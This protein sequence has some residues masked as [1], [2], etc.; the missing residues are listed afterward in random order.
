ML[1]M[2]PIWGEGSLLTPRSPTGRRSRVWGGPVQLCLS[3]VGATLR[4]EGWL[5]PSGKSV[6]RAPRWPPCPWEGT[7]YRHGLAASVCVLRG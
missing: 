6:F 7:D 2:G 4:D 5:G 3:T 1:S